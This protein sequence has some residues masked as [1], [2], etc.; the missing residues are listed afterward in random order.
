ML[1]SVCRKGVRA[2]SEG[3]E[4]ESWLHT[5]WCWD[6]GDIIQFPYTAVCLSTAQ[7]HSPRDRMVVQ[8]T[9]KWELAGCRPCYFHTAVWPES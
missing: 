1:C 6:L 3:L 8:A 4:F 5:Q 9:V 7:G 2:K